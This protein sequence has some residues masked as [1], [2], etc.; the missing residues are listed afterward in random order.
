MWVWSG[1][2]R[3][4]IEDY[5]TPLGHEECVRLREGAIRIENK[6]RPLRDRWHEEDA[7]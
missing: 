5:P 1:P 6:Q 4:V 3:W 7:M 2:P